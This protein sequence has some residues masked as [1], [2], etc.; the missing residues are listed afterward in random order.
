VALAKADE[1]MLN[2]PAQVALTKEGMWLALEVPSFAAMVELEN[3]QQVITALT[4]D[5]AEAR[6]AFLDKRPPAYRNR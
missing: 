6:A 1:I 3:R 4:E 2:G 5:S